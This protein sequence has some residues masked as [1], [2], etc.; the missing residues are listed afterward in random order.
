MSEEIWAADRLRF[1]DNDVQLNTNGPQLFTY[2]NEGRMGG[3]P[4]FQLFR[5]LL[6]YY[7]PL[8]GVPDGCGS[9]CIRAQDAFLDEM[10][11]GNNR[12]MQI[13]HEFLVSHGLASSSVS[14]FKEELRQ[15]WFQDYSRSGGAALDSS[16]FEHVFL[17]E[18]RQ[19]Y[20]G[21]TGFHNWVQA[22]YEEKE[23]ALFYSYKL[24]ICEPYNLKFSFQWYGAE[25]PVSSMWVRTSP[26]VEMALYTLCFQTRPGSACSLRLE[27]EA[28]T[29]RAYTMSGVSPTTVGSVY[30]EC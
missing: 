13:A 28:N 16:G 30:P 17:G 24:D 19:G 22:Y 12:P 3:T 11:N 29:M 14:A 6:P 5:N 2:V 7:E 25:K 20:S 21:V 23:G 26:E 10:F 1:P 4:I 15:Y 27:G 8:I 18:L 9:S